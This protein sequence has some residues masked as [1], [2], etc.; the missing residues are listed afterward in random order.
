MPSLLRFTDRHVISIRNWS[1]NL[2]NGGAP[3][4]P[5]M[6]GAATTQPVGLETASGLTGNAI[7]PACALACR[8][9]C[10]HKQD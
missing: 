10:E 1:I 6:V 4:E 2:F 3:A 8:P 5:A 7:L 9:V